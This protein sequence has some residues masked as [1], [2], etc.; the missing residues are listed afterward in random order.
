MIT[1]HGGCGRNN[2]PGKSE[3][4][5]QRQSN[6]PGRARPAPRGAWNAEKENAEN[7]NAENGIRAVRRIIPSERGIRNKPRVR[8]TGQS[9]SALPFYGTDVDESVTDVLNS[10]PGAVAT[11]TGASAP[12]TDGSAPATG[13]ST[14]ATDPSPTVT[15]THA[16]ATGA[17]EFAT[18]AFESGIGSSAPI[19]GN[20][21]SCAG[22]AELREM[23]GHSCGEEHDSVV[24]PSDAENVS[25]NNLTPG[26][27]RTVFAP[28]RKYVAPRGCSI[29]RS[30]SDV[31]SRCANRGD[32]GL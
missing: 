22:I 31:F 9:R 32:D 3:R 23:L 15:V 19:G 13:A 21:R 20:R 25:S 16:T 14:A 7:G 4:A 6:T 8:E 27:A 29:R 12:A 17:F 2:C 18:G 26:L 11:A 5:V 28:A 1:A 24:D 10:A 30:F